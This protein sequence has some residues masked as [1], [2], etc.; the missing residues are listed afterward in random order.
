L[1]DPRPDAN[2]APALLPSE[3]LLRATSAESAGASRVI[4]GLSV[5]ER[6]VRQLGQLRARRV[7]IATDGTIPIPFAL[8]ANFEIRP[9]GAEGGSPI[10]S[11]DRNVDGR[12][13][14]GADVV[15]CR[16]DDLAAGIRV[17]DE[18]TRRQAEDAVFA[19]LL[20]GDLGF[21]A[22]HINKKI[23]F[24]ITRYFLSR[25]PIT[26]NQVTV[27]AAVI[28]L[29]GC[30]LIATGRYPAMVAG[31]LLAQI[32]SVL[33]GCDGELARVRFQQTAI[34]EW[35]DTVVDDLFNM[36]LIASLGVGLWRA[37]LG[38]PAVAGASAACGMY[39]VYSIVSYRELIRQRL[40][41]EAIKI[42]WKLT[43]GKDMKSLIGARG[44]QGS[45]GMRVLLSLGR[46]DVFIFA[47]LVLAVLNLLPVALIWALLMSLSYFGI[48]IGQLVARDE[49]P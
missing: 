45:A 39:L 31:F 23:S 9:V 41:G 33:D 35:L 47:W 43:R 25:L 32:Q 14:I 18:D 49:P 6:A 34:G 15:R 26:P 27:G 10:E 1:T 12:T 4:G 16:T 7:I 44:N 28:G 13:V 40:G 19:D 8:P 2:P 5:I 11:F 48:A 22:R 21:V 3:I 20:R 36:A 42:R 30:P 17:V 46:R 29:L 24:R 37:K 38:W